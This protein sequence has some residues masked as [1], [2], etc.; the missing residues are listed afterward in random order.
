MRAPLTTGVLTP[1]RVRG[2]DSLPTRLTRQ[3]FYG[4]ECPGPG[5]SVIESVP[6]G[7]TLTLKNTLTGRTEGN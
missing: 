4:T 1:G 2:I 5:R 7:H 3:G 6:P